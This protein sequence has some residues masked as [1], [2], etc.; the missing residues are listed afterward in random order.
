MLATLAADFSQRWLATS[1]LKRLVAERNQQTFSLLSAATIEALIVED[2]PVL[3]TIVSQSVA[4][5]PNIHEVTIRNEDGIQLAKWSRGN[6]VAD[7]H[8]LP[9]QDEFLFEGELFGS[10]EVIWDLSQQ[11]GEIEE[12]VSHSRLLVSGIVV[13]LTLVIL[14]IVHMLAVRHINRINQ[15]IMGLAKGDLVTKVSVSAS[16]ELVHLADSV[17]SLASVLELNEQQKDELRLSASV[18]DGTSD[19]II[20]TDSDGTIIQVNKGFTE[21]T[22]YSSEEMLG[23]TPSLIHSDKH[24]E[25]FY[26]ERRSYLKRNG[27]WQGEIWNRCKDG[28]ILPFWQNITAV[29]DEHGK[30]KQYIGVFS[31]ISEKKISEE[32][33][34]YLA[35]YDVL[36]DLP[37]RLLFEERCRHAMERSNRDGHQLAVLFL[38]LDNFK[39]INDSL[40]HAIG[41]SVLK[42]AADRLTA[43][44]R[45][46]DTVARL[47]GD[48][49][50]IITERLRGP[51]DAD[52]VARKL[53]HAF[54]RPFEVEGQKLRITPSLGISIYPD[55]GDD[56]STLIKNADAAMYRAKEQGRNNYQFYTQELT[57]QALERST[58]T[59]QLSRALEH[60]ELKLHYQPQ[61]SLKSG[62]VTGV[63]AL[64]RWDHSEHG[65]VPPNKFIRLAEDSGLIIPI[66]EWVIQT[67]CQDF[68]RWKAQELPLPQVSVNVAGPQIQRGGFV[69]TVRRVLEDT[70]IDPNCLELE[71][72]EGF[73]MREADQ[74]I[75]TLI[76]LKS[77][78]VMLAIDDFGTGYS[79]LS[80][81]K[82]LPIDRLKID[83]SFVRDIPEDA[84]DMAIT[85]AI[86]SLGANLQLEVIAEG[87]ETNEQ[88]EFLRSEGCVKVQGFLYSQ[89]LPESELVSFLGSGIR[90]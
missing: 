47:G 22:G 19:A 81:L 7:T 78:G 14:T 12:H 86:L 69:K 46:E 67:A 37:N 25:E 49:F 79:S 5:I 66:G 84:D 85:K 30:V 52:Q 53:M 61:F 72:T 87:V 17:N 83:R 36:T 24:T 26:E 10:L 16:Q 45:D 33:I 44:L 29:K 18:F 9:F 80:Y 34:R 70:G 38:D 23:N 74:A 82:R 63:E 28:R 76:E 8:L 39:N 13:V 71:I 43:L 55:N 1:Y 73:I 60:E 21:I 4:T 89:P 42:L 62:K 77:L 68:L 90:L 27:R 50:T 32:R 48:E 64:L 20:V 40:G 65:L 35:H 56:V 51:T 75:S 41:D 15:R 58:M 88:Q 6:E 11:H 57:V 54:S 59:A 2:G 3:E 31:D